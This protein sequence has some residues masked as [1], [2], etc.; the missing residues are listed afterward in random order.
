MIARTIADAGA[1]LLANPRPIL[2]LDTCDVLNL[3]Q[4]VTTIPLAELAAV[5]RL[6]ATL[7]SD[8]RECQPVGTYVSAIEYLQKTD[9]TNPVYQ[10]DR[11][12]TKLPPDAVTDRLR[13]I[14]EQIARVHLIRK[15]LGQS[16][17]APVISYAS[18]NLLDTLR[19]KADLLL[20]FCW[21]LQ[22][23]QASLDASIVRVFDKTRPS[24]RREI[25]DSIHLEHCLAL[26]RHLRQ[27]GFTEP[28][29]FTSANINDYGP[30]D[31]T[32]PNPDLQADFAGV[33]MVYFESL[34][35]SIA[36]LGI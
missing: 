12:N 20:D 36:Y 4:V 10:K 24:H 25:K 35:K 21:A 6:L 23:D 19:A 14:D 18:L 31:R 8:P 1:D 28:I 16:L 15:E 5:N 7:D 2:F 32:R 3:L 27:R 33:Q 17:P 22:P 34:S 13:E 11:R 26:A 29:V 30:E 9:A